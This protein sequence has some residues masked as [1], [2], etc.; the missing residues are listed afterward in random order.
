MS[1]QQKRLYHFSSIKQMMKNE[2][3]REGILSN[4]QIIKTMLNNLNYEPP[5][6]FIIKLTGTLM[7]LTYLHI[8][9]STFV[10]PHKS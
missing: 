8:F 10:L 4:E 6:Y 3:K 1:G 9:E 2:L 7:E 5:L